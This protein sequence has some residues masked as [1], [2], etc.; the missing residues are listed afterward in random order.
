MNIALVLLISTLT[1]IANNAMAEEQCSPGKHWVESHLRRAYIRYDGVHV[2][3]TQVKGHCR[4]KPK[5][6]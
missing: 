5:R 4:E 3:E 6:I 1:L 2:K